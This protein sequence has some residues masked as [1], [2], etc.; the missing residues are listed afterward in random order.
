MTDL[1]RTTYEPS[2]ANND[3][4][5]AALRD[6]NTDPT[7]NPEATMPDTT[8]LADVKAVE[9]E[10]YLTVNDANSP[11]P[12]G[13]ILRSNEPGSNAI[14]Q[15]SAIEKHDEDTPLFVLAPLTPGMVGRW[16]REDMIARWSIVAR[17]D[18][19]LS[20]QAAKT[21]ING[22]T[23]RLNTDI[24]T[25]EDRIQTLDRKLAT[26][27]GNINEAT[28]LLADVNWQDLYDWSR[29]THTSVARAAVALG[30]NEDDVYPPRDFVG[31]T[32]ITI[33]VSMRT[34]ATNAERA[35]E[36]MNEWLEGAMDNLRLDSSYSSRSGDVDADIDSTDFDTFDAEEA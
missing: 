5:A 17:P 12:L 30:M 3:A 24:A 15:L 33:R 22:L 16:G 29:D 28:S 23:F 21:L 32:N 13:T 2:D 10:F 4:L 11:C 26:T 7:P 20:V 35:T 6:A 14:V 9:T 18:D 34:E 27:L 19:L 1:P 31:F 36:S 8:P 25:R